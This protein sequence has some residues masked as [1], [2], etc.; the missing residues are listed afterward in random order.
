MEQP[1][2]RLIRPLSTVFAVALVAAATAPRANAQI[3]GFIRLFRPYHQ[4]SLAQL[5]D[6][7]KE[8]KLTDEQKT[9]IVEI[10]D[11]LNE[12]RGALFQQAN[13]DFESIRE[14][15]TKLNA[16]SAKEVNKLLDETQ[17]KRLAQIYVQANGPTALF[18][19]AIAAELKL[20]D[21]Q[22]TKLADVRN[23]QFG[24]FQGVDWQSLSE[25]EANKKIDEI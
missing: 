22:K 19:D 16:E 6:V 14:D 11:K 24:A 2:R 23:A 12:D 7:A 3:A 21:E 5:P 13:G 4:S 9:K 25:D 18:D 20:T 1:M 10:Y 8:L 17:Q 15:M